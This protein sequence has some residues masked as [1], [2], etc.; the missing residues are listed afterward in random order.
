VAG[1]SAS[2]EVREAMPRVQLEF[3]VE[4]FVD[5]RPGPHVRAAIAAV[6]ARGLDV[7]MGPFSTTAEA[8]DAVAIDAVAGLLASALEAGASRV[9]LQVSRVAEGP[10]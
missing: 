9:S 10:A 3:T 6:E 1:G 7:D 8:E 5:G 4:P 2:L